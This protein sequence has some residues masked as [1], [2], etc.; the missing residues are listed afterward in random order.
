M[1]LVKII[2]YE[3]D[4]SVFVWKSPIENFNTMS[5]LIVHESQEAV[6]SKTGRL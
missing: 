5:Q 2:K 4:N 6:F 1:A 3:G